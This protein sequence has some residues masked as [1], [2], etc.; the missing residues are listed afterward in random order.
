MSAFG[1]GRRQVITSE[2]ALQI[3][4]APG[5]TRAALE[6][7]ATLGFELRRPVAVSAIDYGTDPVVGTLVGLTRDEV[8]LERHDARAGR[9][10]VHFPRIGYQV[11]KHEEKSR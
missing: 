10:V 3:A 2:R 6:F 8:A 7:D 11:R 5:A 9:V 1:H 4:A